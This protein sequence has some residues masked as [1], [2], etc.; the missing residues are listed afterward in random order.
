MSLF[1]RS[2]QAAPAYMRGVFI[3]A[4]MN[5]NQIPLALASVAVSTGQYTITTSGDGNA[6]VSAS[7]NVYTGTSL[8]SNAPYLQEPSGPNTPKIARSIFNDLCHLTLTHTASGGALALQVVASNTQ[9]SDLRIKWS[10][11]GYNGASATAAMVPSATNGSGD[12][13]LIWGG[14]SDGSPSGSSV[15]GDAPRGT[16]RVTIAVSDDPTYPFLYVLVWSGP[17]LGAPAPAFFLAWDTVVRAPSQA[18]L[19]PNDQ[20]CGCW[21]TPTFSQYLSPAYLTGAASEGWWGRYGVG[22]QLYQFRMNAGSLPGTGN[23]IGKLGR[24]AAGRTAREFPSL[25]RDIV[26]V[27]QRGVKGMLRNLEV[28]TRNIGQLQPLDDADADVRSAVYRCGDL[29]VPLNRFGAN[30][31]AGR[32]V[33]P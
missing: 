8:D 17:V 33:R 32:L 18:S 11:G 30:G 3:N 22:A 7:G 1:H 12:D 28:C 19:D 24:S 25:E 27:T 21:P 4:R 14:G 29:L 5:A 23:M 6:I 31:A 26:D 16:S 20:V 2:T 9:T 15:L 10:P 13:A